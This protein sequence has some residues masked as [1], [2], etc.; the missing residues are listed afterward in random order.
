M[1][2]C[3]L[4]TY[5]A[6]WRALT[7]CSDSDKFYALHTAFSPAKAVQCALWPSTL[8]SEEADVLAVPL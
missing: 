4:S 6:H 1:L 3:S 8:G 5:P 7:W 2:Y